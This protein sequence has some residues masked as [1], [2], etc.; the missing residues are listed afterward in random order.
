MGITWIDLL[1]AF[2]GGLFGA[3]IGGLPA[4][5]FTGFTLLVGIGLALSGAVTFDFS[6]SIAFGPVLAPPVAFGGGVAAAAYAARRGILKSGKD[7]TSGL[8]GLNAPDVLLVGG[9]FGLLG[10]AV[11]KILTYLVNGALDAGGLTV[12]LSAIA[13]R[14]IFGTTG[15]FGTPTEEAAKRG[16]FVPGG[17][18]VWVPYQ[19]DWLQVS[20]IGLG[21]GLMSSWAAL[22]VAAADPDL[23]GIGTLI[24]F[25]IS[26]ASLIFMQA[27]F[28]V[29]VTH[30]MTLVAATAASASGSLLV[31]ALFGVIAAIVGECASR[32]MLIHGDTHIDPP[33]NAIWILT[34]LITIL[35]R[36]GII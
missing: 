26:A 13:V 17:D 3:A 6:G 25:G 23:A 7:I 8:A 2:G 33:A 36:I 30:H 32:L 27:G 12:I 28:N 29:P 31:G 34:L 18:Q 10:F 19:Q 16:R 5:I 35:N 15:F 14:L 21:A 9:L 4:F 20:V 1:G 11:M 24:G 22:A